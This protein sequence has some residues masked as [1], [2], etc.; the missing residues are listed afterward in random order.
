[1]NDNHPFVHDARLDLIHR[2]TT[3]CRQHLR[4]HP[5]E[6]QG[7]I[8]AD[9]M[10]MFVAGH[11]PS[12]RETLLEQ[13]LETICGLVPINEAIMFEGKGHPEKAL[14]EEGHADGND[15]H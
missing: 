2:I 6:I 9:L 1:M 4:G 13:L 5:P 7:A 10:S 8:L 14:W 11:A 12:L 15:H 3:E